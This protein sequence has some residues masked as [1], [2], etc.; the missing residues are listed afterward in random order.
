MAIQDQQLSFFSKEKQ[1]LLRQIDA[2]QDNSK[3]G[4]LVGK[5]VI[6]EDKIKNRLQEI[7]NTP[8]QQT[9]SLGVIEEAVSI[10]PPTDNSFSSNKPQDTKIKTAEKKDEASNLIE[11][12]KSK[13]YDSSQMRKILSNAYQQL[14]KEIKKVKQ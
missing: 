6:L 14:Y 13:G 5:L 12:L 4:V 3:R 9:T 2:E 11:L 7:T 10:K 1:E 8:F